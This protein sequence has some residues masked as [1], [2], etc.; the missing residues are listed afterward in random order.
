MPDSPP[1]SRPAPVTHLPRTERHAR[2]LYLLDASGIRW[3]VLAA[4]RAPPDWTLTTKVPA[5]VKNPARLFI[6]DDGL[7][8]VY[9]PSGYGFVHPY[10]RRDWTAATLQWQLALATLIRPEDTRRAGR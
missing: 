10:D 1:P 6:R 7:A 5:W 3:R 4:H 8:R 2:K 9:D